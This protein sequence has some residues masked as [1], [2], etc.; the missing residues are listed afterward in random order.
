MPGATSY[1]WTVPAGSTINSG[2]GTTSIN[3]TAGNTSGNITVTA[4]YPCGTSGPTTFA[5]SINSSPTVTASSTV[6]A[7]CAGGSVTLNGGGASTYAW[8]GGVIN[9]VSFVPVSTLTYTVTGTAVNGCTNTATTTV[10]V[11][12]LP[13]V[14]ANSSSAAVCNGGSVTLT[15]GGAA[16]YTWDNS[17]VNAVSFVPAATNTYMVTGTDVNGCVNTATTS[18]TVNLLPTVSASSTT[19]VVCLGGSV[20]LTGGGATNYT[21]DNNVV[22]GVSFVPTATNTYMVTGTDANGCTNTATTTVTVNTLPL[23]TANSTSSTVC[24]GSSVILTGGGATTFTWDNNVVD[25]ASFVPTSTL[26]YMVTGTDVN[27]CENTATITVTVNPLPIVT[28][29]AASSVVCIDDASVT[30]TG[31]PAAGIWSGLGVTGSTFNPSTAG[32]GAQTTTYTFTDANGCVD[33]ANAI[34]QVNACTGVI[35]TTLANGVN[36]FP[37]PNAGSFGISVNANVGNMTIE[38]LDLQGRVVY[39]SLEKNVQVGFAKQISIGNVANG[40]YVLRLTTT[41]EQNII[42]VSVQ[43]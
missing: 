4:T 18:I 42:K 23:V 27:G 35:E 24:A 16:S 37:N 28:A 33:F 8:S 3:I 38:M 6:A 12:A 2:Q 25:D 29:N 19:A 39:S 32:L 9:A 21:W 26:T 40:V 41:S 31:T 20:T 7:V 43:K 11:N 17:V 15:G 14:T 5:L 30:L 1:S 13:S 10:T 22:D 34:I 36:V